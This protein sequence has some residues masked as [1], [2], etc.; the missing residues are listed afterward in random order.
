MLK[1]IPWLHVYSY[2]AIES[3]F[4]ILSDTMENGLAVFQAE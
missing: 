4:G 3:M 1:C 2:I